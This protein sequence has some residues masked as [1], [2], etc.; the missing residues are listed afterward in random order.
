V[1]GSAYGSNAAIIYVILAV[2]GAVAFIAVFPFAKTYK[3]DIKKIDD[4]LKE[5]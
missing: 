3:N 2:L 1:L 4:E 5:L